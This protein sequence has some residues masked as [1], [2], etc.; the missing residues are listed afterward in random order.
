[1]GLVA[2]GMRFAN[3]LK[4][5]VVV[6][7]LDRRIFAILQVNREVHHILALCPLDGG[8]ERTH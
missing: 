8:D 1:M 6:C 4:A 3:A 2:R 5:E 7:Y